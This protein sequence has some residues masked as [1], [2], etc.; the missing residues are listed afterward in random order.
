MTRLR[1]RGIDGVVAFALQNAQTYA[2][3]VPDA[4]PVKTFADLKGQRVG[5][6]SSGSLTESL[7]SLQAKANNL[8][9]GTDLEVIG[10]GVGA[11]QKAA[12]DTQRIAAGMFGNTDALQMVGHGY[13]IV[14]D[15]RVER[16][17]ALGLLAVDSWQKQHPEL[18]K[19]VIQATLKAQKL[20]LAD[21]QL[22]VST[23]KEL[24]PDLSDEV[25][26]KA[27]DQLPKV[28]VASGIFDQA[29]HDK[30]QKDLATIEPGLKPIDYAVG[31]PGTYLK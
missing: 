15:W 17:P 8:T 29:D 31:N 20:V 10:A 25:I 19:G 2:L 14:Y 1:A 18:A 6:T 24:F 7:I 11:A 27:A 26:Q 3:L 22:A 5:I 4:S 30:L 13:R 21:R 12:L 9:V 23:L 16:T 28:L